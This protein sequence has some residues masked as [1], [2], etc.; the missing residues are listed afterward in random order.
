MRSFVSD[1]ILMARLTKELPAFLKLPL[2]LQQ[3]LSEIKARLEQR[4]QRFLALARDAIFSNPQSPYLKLLRSTGCGKRDLEELVAKEGLDGAL[5][6]L[7]DKGVAV[8][9]DEFKGYADA[10]RGSDRF[11]FAA[12]DF[13]NP[14]SDA[15]FIM[16][17][18]G[19][20]SAE[21]TVPVGLPY[22]EDLSANTAVALS[23]NGLWDYDHAI[24]MLSTGLMFSL[25]LAKLGRSPL[26][27]FYP[28]DSRTWKLQA[29]MKWLRSLGAQAGCR[30]PSPDCMELQDPARMARWLRDQLVEGKRM[31][32]TCYASSAARVSLAAVEEGFELEGACFITLGEPYTAAKQQAIERSGARGLVHF[33]MTEAGLLGF[34]C[35][36]AGT[37]DDVHFF[38]DA[39]GLIQRPHAVGVD[40]FLLTTLLRSG[41]KV[42]LNVDTG[43]YGRVD[44]HS[45]GCGLES[46][47]L[48]DHISDIRSFEKLTSEGMT[49][50]KSDLTRILE[51]ALPARF[52]GASSDYQV[53]E[54][55]GADGLQELALLIAP[56][57]GLIDEA[58]AIKLFLDELQSEGGYQ[59]MG[60]SIW[61]RL[62]TLN[63]L[64]RDPFATK[65]GKIVPYHLTSH[66]RVEDAKR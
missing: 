56:R 9:F 53:V 62:Q 57:V 23:A 37:S 27:W 22:I 20:R 8:S 25:R 50:V 7:A 51:E 55:E 43:D 34:S 11:S 30:L 46:I 44:T 18:G 63:V 45:C 39:Y 32:L 13:N 28:V 10:V 64:R 33:G 52:G 40:G 48:C 42:M 1:A 41:P 60:A 47:G 19:T 15:R 24:W 58:Q 5:A 36:K 4:E 26:A 61:Q 31:C 21:T 2:S 59:K 35:P 66:I 16:R 38:R 54:Q 49:F 29:G 17:S 14:L 3:A 12:S 6:C 65:A